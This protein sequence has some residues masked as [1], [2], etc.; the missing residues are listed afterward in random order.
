MTARATDLT[1]LTDR[2]LKR[3][4]DSAAT[5]LSRLQTEDERRWDIRRSGGRPERLKPFVA[6]ITATFW[7]QVMALDA[8]NVETIIRNTNL[9]RLEGFPGNEIERDISDIEKVPRTLRWIE[10]GTGEAR[11]EPARAPQGGQ[12]IRDGGAAEAA[13]PPAARRQRSKRTRRI[14]TRAV[15]ELGLLKVGELEKL[16]D[17]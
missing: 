1:M 4:L 2:E 16:D 13:S 8:E 3:R 15:E 14:V 10:M 7:V 11:H 9:G 12:G 6:T 5:T 17:R